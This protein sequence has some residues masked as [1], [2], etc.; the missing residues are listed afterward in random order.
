MCASP[1]TANLMLVKL[2]QL[3][4]GRMGRTFV[5]SDGKNIIPGTS[6]SRGAA[7]SDIRARSPWFRLADLSAC[8]EEAHSK[9]RF[10]AA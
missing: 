4:V 9:G 2:R 3:L 10:G 5:T 8:S 6:E 1:R 7:S